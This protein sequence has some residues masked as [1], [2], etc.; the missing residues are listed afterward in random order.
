[1]FSEGLWSD[2]YPDASRPDNAAGVN[3]GI[4]AST[5]ER[6]QP[7]LTS[8]RLDAKNVPITGGIKGNR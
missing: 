4:F 8:L 7:P 6:T 5:V 3:P 2:Y 1:M